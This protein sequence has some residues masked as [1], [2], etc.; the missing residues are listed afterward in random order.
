MGSRLVPCSWP[1][2]SRFTRSRETRE[3][4]REREGMRYDGCDA[5]GYS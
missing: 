3:R 5:H 4:E 1:M 2:C